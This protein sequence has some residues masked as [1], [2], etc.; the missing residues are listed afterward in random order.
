MFEFGSCSELQ[1]ASQEKHVIQKLETMNDMRMHA[2]GFAS[3]YKNTLMHTKGEN[4]IKIFYFY[5]S[6]ILL[7][8]IPI[9]VNK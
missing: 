7:W 9:V 1:T 2:D 4:T 5:F 3:L 8:I 6:T